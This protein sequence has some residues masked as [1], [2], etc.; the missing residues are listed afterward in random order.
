[1]SHTL[2]LSLLVMGD[3]EAHARVRRVPCVTIDGCKSEC[4]RRNVELAGGTVAERVQVMD[5]L[6][7][8][9]GLK[10][11]AVTE[12]DED[13]QVLAGFVADEAMRA[14]DRTIA[15]VACKEVAK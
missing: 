13:G 9:R 3:E 4:A 5:V 8:H 14:V 2:C 6:K 12:L 7:A 15:S 10:P 1:M 11:K